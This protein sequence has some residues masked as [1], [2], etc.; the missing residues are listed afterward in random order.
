MDYFFLYWVELVSQVG[1]RYSSSIPTVSRLAVG[2]LEP[3]SGALLMEVSAHRA[4]MRA[5]LRL[6]PDG[7]DPGSIPRRV[8]LPHVLHF[9]PTAYCV[10]RTPFTVMNK[11]AKI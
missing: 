3:H 10:T 2:G 11:K 9:S 4:C 8:H 7:S 1:L 5:P 6:S